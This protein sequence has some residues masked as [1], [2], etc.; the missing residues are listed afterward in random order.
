MITIESLEQK[1][2]QEAA[3]LFV[4][5][6]K[7]Q[8]KRL[9]YL[10]AQYENPEVAARLLQDMLTT[11]TGV[12]AIS[13]GRLVGYLTG[14]A[15]I[16]HFKGLSQGAYVPEWAHSVA[17]EQ[18]RNA[19]F[20]LMYDRIA[21]EWID[22]GSYTQAIT[23]FASDTALQ[24]LLY[25]NGFGMV[26]V[27]AIRLCQGD[28]NDDASLDANTIIRQ[29]HADDLPQLIQLDVALRQY[30]ARSPVFFLFQEH[31]YDQAAQEFLGEDIVSAVA[32]QN[33]RLVAC[34]RGTMQKEDGCT[35]V[36]DESVMGINF[37]YTDP[38]VRGTGIG[39]RLLAY[40]LAWGRR[41]HKVGCAVDFES[42]NVLG[43]IFWL[44]HF[45]AACFSAIR[46]ADPRITCSSTE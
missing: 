24:D 39:R 37:G 38:N 12:A 40:V 17:G 45:Q 46:F 9:D 15:Q 22:Q 35:I 1:H 3:E 19:T 27:D 20:Q 44:K 34:I 23:Y 8:R 41:S 26:T 43:R 28:E 4:D 18:G 42:A 13:N 31:E 30:L 6:Y 16:P 33:G 21:A 32:E 14:Y 2:I 5:S 10:P 25:W 7:A 29:A 36:R 11:Q